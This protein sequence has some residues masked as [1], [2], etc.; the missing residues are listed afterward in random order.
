MVDSKADDFY[1]QAICLT[2]VIVRT[3]E[4]KGG[5]DLSTKPLPK[6]RHIVAANK[7]MRILS[8]G[9][10][11]GTTYISAINFYKD[12]GDLEKNKALGAL[13]IYIGE[14][15]IVDM[16]EEMGYP[17][18]DEND[19]DLMKDAVGTF[20]NIVAG[21]FKLALTQL[22]FIELEMSHFSTYID[23]ISDGVAYDSKQSRKYEIIFE[24]DDEK[25]IIAE[26]T[27]G[28]TP[29]TLYTHEG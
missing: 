18:L 15:Y 13:I 11:E 7:K 27:M 2:Q 6:I 26:L 21:K 22:D 24:I 14:A 28:P 4:Q 29:K 23:E 10:F 17:D 12:D 1:L 5:I 8:L 3:L 16:F 9:K 25:K 20:C 19:E